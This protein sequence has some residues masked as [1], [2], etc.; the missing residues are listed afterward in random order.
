MSTTLQ[1]Q[2]F[3]PLDTHRWLLVD[4]PTAAA[5]ATP[6]EKT[7]SYNHTLSREHP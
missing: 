7:P 4:A 3:I 1:Q 2:Q 5:D 6:H